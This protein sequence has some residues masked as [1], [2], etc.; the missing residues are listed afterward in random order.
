MHRI[1]TASAF[2]GLSGILCGVRHAEMN[3]PDAEGHPTVD[4]RGLSRIGR[5]EGPGPPQNGWVDDR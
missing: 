1:D 3:S 5:D 2:Y 4:L